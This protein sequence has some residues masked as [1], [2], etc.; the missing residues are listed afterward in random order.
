MK[1]NKIS[2]YTILYLLD[3]YYV[4]FLYYKILRA[5]VQI[6]KQHS[7]LLIIYLSCSFETIS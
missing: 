5:I 6:I 2:Y 7:A 3:I 4:F 1:S